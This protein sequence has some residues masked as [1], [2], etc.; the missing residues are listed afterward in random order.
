MKETN[1]KEVVKEILKYLDETVEFSE[2]HLGNSDWSDGVKFAERNLRN[3]IT[4]I[5]DIFEGK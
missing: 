2:E 4:R 5:V 3:T 1:Y